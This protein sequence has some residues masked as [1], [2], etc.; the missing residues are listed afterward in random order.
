[1]PKPTYTTEDRVE[2]LERAVFGDESLDEKGMKK[3]VDEIHDLLVQA[4]GI[5]L[6]FGGVRGF[7]GILIVIASAWA[8]I[9]G[10]FN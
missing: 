7:F 5:G 9:K 10:W 2:I 8:L 4:K 3:K 1:M 6:F